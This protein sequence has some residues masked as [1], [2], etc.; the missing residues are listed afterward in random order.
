MIFES[1]KYYLASCLAASRQLE[2]ATVLDRNGASQVESIEDN[3]LTHVITNSPHFD[4]AHKVRQGAAIVADKWVDRCMQQGKLQPTSIYSPDPAMLFSGVVATSTGISAT[5]VEVLAA[6]ITA[7][8]G[9]WR[10]ALTRDI[11]HIFAVPGV[12][13]ASDD[14]ACVPEPNTSKYHMAKHAQVQEL[15]MKILLPHWFDDAVRLGTGSLPTEEYEWPEPKILKPSHTKDT[16]LQITKDTKKMERTPASK[17]ALIRSQLWTPDASTPMPKPSKNIWGS[18]RVLLSYTIGLSPERQLT[19]ESTIE[20][21]GGV[22]VRKPESQMDLDE[23][24]EETILVDEAD[25]LITRYRAGKAYFKALTSH[26]II[27]SLSWLF[28]VH[29]SAI[30]SPPTDQLLHYPLPRRGIDGFSSHE[31]SITNYTGEAREYIKKLIETMGATFTPSM[32]SRNTVLIAAFISGTKTAKA[33]SWSIP[34]VN[35]TWLEDCFVRWRHLTVGLEKYIVFPPNVDFAKMLCERSLGKLR[36]IEGGVLTI[37]AAEGEQAVSLVHH[38]GVAGVGRGM[39]VDIW[40][41]VDEKI[42]GGART[43]VEGRAADDTS[44]KIAR[45]KEGT[46]SLVPNTSPM[47]KKGDGTAARRSPRKAG[48]APAGPPPATATSARDVMEISNELAPEGATS[49][50]EPEPQAEPEPESPSRRLSRKRKRRS[51]GRDSPERPPSQIESASPPR[52][53]QKLVSS[54]KEPAVANGNDSAEDEDSD[55]LPEVTTAL[56]INKA[57]K[58]ADNGD[59]VMADEEREDSPIPMPRKKLTRRSGEGIDLSR[60]GMPISPQKSPN[61]ASPVAAQASPRVTMASKMRGSP[62][63]AAA[64]VPKLGH[65]EGDSRDDEVQAT[66]K[67]K[68]MAK[69]AKPPASSA[70]RI[71]KG[72]AKKRIAEE[73]EEEEEGEEEE[74]QVVAARSSK[75]RTYTVKATTSRRAPKPARDEGDS[76]TEPPEAPSKPSRTAKAKA[77]KPASPIEIDPPE[78]DA[79]EGETVTILKSPQVKTTKKGKQAQTTNLPVPDAGGSRRLGEGKPPAPDETNFDVD[80]RDDGGKPTKVLKRPTPKQRDAVVEDDLE[81]PDDTSVISG[82][83]RR[84]AAAKASQVL[85][86]TIMPDVNMYQK[87]MSRSRKSGSLPNNFLQED[88]RSRASTPSE[89]PPKAKRKVDLDAEPPT[90]SNKPKC[91]ASN[92]SPSK[93]SAKRSRNIRLMTTQVTLSDSV[94]K[95]LVKLGVKMVE[96]ASECTH[97]L[98]PHLVRTEKFLCAIAVN[99]FILKSEWATASAAANELLPEETY[100]LED[101]ANERKYNVKLADVLLRAKSNQG[102][103]FAKKT[104]HVTPKVSIDLKLLKNVIAANGGQMTTQAPTSRTFNSENKYLISCPEDASIWRPFAQHRPVY[105]TELVLSGAL[106]QEV[107]WDTDAS[108]VPGSF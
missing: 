70:T 21:A 36:E 87:H 6:G 25:V 1:V 105:T 82:R 76:T 38:L 73:E 83:S 96:K 4:G 94:V 18:R 15:S 41:G 81:R 28:H 86:D 48:H 71:R 47:S 69:L 40:A 12:G 98:A 17:R 13:V 72:K 106:K 20:R 91:G 32:T 100:F 90:N 33:Q 8:G 53:R 54:P 80:D 59:V 39:E 29:S 84:T 78:S 99:A 63:K 16:G 92:T 89:R 74:V 24:E 55:S 103:L 11:T 57:P 35:H 9:Q 52:L 3:S 5:D 10:T 60:L 85:H 88:T 101:D 14:D 64:A 104:F 37:A 102:Q 67:T 31:I 46:T 51:D 7:L 79:V 42:D 23:D 45:N 68:L 56:G 107:D 2:L 93:L 50:P 75:G 30:L 58:D 108:K 61:K 27:G 97:L 77:K 43:L 65:E 62:A 34:I 19:L 22:V 26:K 66:T 95:R 49:E 44:P